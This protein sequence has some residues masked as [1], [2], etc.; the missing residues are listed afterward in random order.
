MKGNKDRIG[1][2][3]R[4]GS[5]AISLDFKKLHGRREFF[6]AVKDYIKDNPNIELTELDA[7]FQY[8]TGASESLIKQALAV[9]ENI[10]L[11][12]S[13]EY[14]EDGYRIMNFKLKQKI[15]GEGK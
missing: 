11:I 7:Y 10:G 12:E 5:I 2:S 1:K 9:L 15:I 13:K 6:D 8:T 14:F 3:D 4:I